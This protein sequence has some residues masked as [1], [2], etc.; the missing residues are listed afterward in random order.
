M[1]KT[2]SR[3]RAWQLKKVKEGKCSICGRLNLFKGGVCRKH[4]KQKVE[5]AADWHKNNK[6]KH[7][8]MMA[9]WR[10]KNSEYMNNYYHKNKNK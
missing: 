9:D 7:L 2:I 1:K 8:E 10:K 5:Q 6:E 4:Y 3:Q